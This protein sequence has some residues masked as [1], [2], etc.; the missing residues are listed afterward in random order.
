ML[1][2]KG[3]YFGKAGD[4]I[5]SLQIVVTAII[6]NAIIIFLIVAMFGIALISLIAKGMV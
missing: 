4:K 5:D 6:I 2:M 3:I 1:V